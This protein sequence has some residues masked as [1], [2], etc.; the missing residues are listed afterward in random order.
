MWESRRPYFI[1]V[2]DVRQDGAL[3]LGQQ[4]NGH[5]P[6]LCPQN[7]QVARRVAREQR[8]ALIEGSAHA[9]V[10]HHPVEEQL[11]LGGSTQ[12]D[13]RQREEDRNTVRNHRVI[14]SKMYM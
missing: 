3:A 1:Q 11:Q 4:R 14:T 13:R 5:R 10:A 8:E 6:Q 2:G 12:P 9:L 7:R